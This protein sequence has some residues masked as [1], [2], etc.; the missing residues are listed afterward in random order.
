MFIAKTQCLLVRKIKKKG[1]T[2]FFGQQIL[3]A[4]DASHRW[5][6][7]YQSTEITKGNNSKNNLKISCT[8]SGYSNGFLMMVPNR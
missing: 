6:Q 5:V 8:N 2:Y 3:W 4:Y 7:L 1:R